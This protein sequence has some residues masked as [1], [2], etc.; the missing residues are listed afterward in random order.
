MNSSSIN[1]NNKEVAFEK[2]GEQVFCTSLDIARVF[3]K[4]HKNVLRSIEH[5]LKDLRK[6]GT[7]FDQLNFEPSMRVTKN[8]IFDKNTKLYKLTKDGFAILAMG[9]TGTKA[10]QWKIQFINA[11]NQMQQLIQREIKSPNEYLTDMM[12]DIYPNLPKEDYRVDI[13]IKD[14]LN[15]QT[16]QE[17]YKLSYLVDNRIPKDPL[18]EQNSKENRNKALKDEVKKI[19]EKNIQ[20]KDKDIER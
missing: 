14:S 1:I 9:F 11:F 6:I 12:K 16:A 20:A 17:I 5:T 18:K 10:L 8:G 4:E 7:S 19:S 3:E 15:P 13:S 2:Q